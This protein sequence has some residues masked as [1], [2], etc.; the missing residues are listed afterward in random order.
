MTPPELQGHQASLSMHYG[1]TSLPQTAHNALQP[2]NHSY[3]CDIH[4]FLGHSG[5]VLDQYTNMLRT[6]HYEE[7]A[8]ALT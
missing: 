1:R 3:T 8:I 4:V 7:K 6:F 2:K 5:L